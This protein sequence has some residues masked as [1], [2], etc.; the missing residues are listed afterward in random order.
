MR[1]LR[2]GID[3]ACSR[4][5]DQED[6]ILWSHDIMLTLVG[7]SR[8]VMGLS[9][10]GS[11]TGLQLFSCA[12]IAPSPRTDQRAKLRLELW[13]EFCPPKRLVQVLTPILLFG[14]KIF[15]GVIKLK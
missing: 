7:L 13:F 4:F 8:L 11:N 14:N 9:W 2:L 5:C 1:K 10:G 3:M 15:A 12:G 6:E